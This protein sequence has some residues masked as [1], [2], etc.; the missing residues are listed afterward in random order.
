MLPMLVTGRYNFRVIITKY[1]SWTF[2]NT[3]ECPRGDALREWSSPVLY[4]RKVV[5]L[6]TLARVTLV[7]LCAEGGL[8]RGFPFSPVLIMIRAWISPSQWQVNAL[9]NFAQ[10]FAFPC[11][12]RLPFVRKQGT[13][14]RLRKIFRPMGFCLSLLPL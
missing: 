8:F 13:C 14:R 10:Q 5:K 1:I 9:S 11:V 6:K 3:P 2:G 7:L 12:C 4:R